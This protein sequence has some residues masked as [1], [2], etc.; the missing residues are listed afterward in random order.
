MSQTSPWSRVDPVGMATGDCHDPTLAVTADTLH[1]V[2][3]KGRLIHH[4]RYTDGVWHAPLRFAAGEQPVLAAGN[5]G[6]LHCLFANWF[7][8]NCEIYHVSFDGERWSFPE[9]VSR[10]PGVSTQP[11]VAID[12][13]GDGHA[14]WSDDTP[15]YPVVYYAKRGQVAWLHAPL[16]NVTGA[17]PAIAVAPAGE[18]YVAWQERVALIENGQ[19]LRGPYQ[20]L[21]CVHKNG[22]WELPELVSEDRTVDALA[23][24]LAAGP[25]GDVHVAWQEQHAG[26]F[27][28]KYATRLAEGW[29]RSG[30][31]SQGESDA[32]LPHAFA[33][34]HGVHVLWLEGG[35]IKHRTRAPAPD[36]PW[37]KI[38]TVAQ[39]SDLS[40]LS[41]AVAHDGEIHVAWSRF[42]TSDWRSIRYAKRAQPAEHK[43][44]LPLIPGGKR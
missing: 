32:R 10:T 40:Q 28:I 15:G 21:S 35:E 44:F 5:D 25:R 11:A 29:S 27:L 37:N 4:T 8:G 12:H 43:I 3:V 42:E 2:W 33:D 14:V 30:P 16:P 20:I 41:V 36:A 6:T 34:A 23:P 17:Q 24:S 31:I 38:E 1:L 9:W 26:Q 22:K 7:L 13:E 39:D 19:V 18:V